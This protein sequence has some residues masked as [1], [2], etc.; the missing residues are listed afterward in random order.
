MELLNNEVAMADID[1]PCFSDSETAAYVIEALEGVSKVWTLWSLKH[2]G[3]KL[4][5][6]CLICF[7]FFCF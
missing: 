2:L 7:V 6:L 1:D 3:F 4:Q 5:F